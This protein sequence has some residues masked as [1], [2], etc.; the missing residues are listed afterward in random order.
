[1]LAVLAITVLL[2]PASTATARSELVEWD[3][4]GPDRPRIGLLGD[5]TLAGVR[6]AD[7]YGSL[8]RFNYVFDAQSC[9][10]TV[11]RSCWSREQLRPDNAI[12]ALRDHRDRWGQVLVVMMGYNDSASQFDDGVE[13]IVAE[14]RRQ[15]IGQV[16]WLSLRTKGVDY[17]E[18]LHKA[19]GSTYRSANRSLYAA[20]AHEA[21]YLQVADWASA[22]ADRPEWFGPDGVHLSPEGVDALTEFIATQV[23]ALL[24]GRTITPS[25]VPWEVVRSGDQGQIVIDVQT[26]L[27]RAG[28]DE[29]GGAD[30]D[31]GEQTVA[32]VEALQ[33]D[34]DLPITGEVDD[35]TA[36][37]L[38]L[39]TPPAS[40]AG[41][42]DAAPAPP[43]GAT[44]GAAMIGPPLPAQ[45]PGR[46]SGGEG[47]F[48]F[49]AMWTVL[50]VGGLVAATLA[51][52]RF[53]AVRGSQRQRRR[54]RR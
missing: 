6:W 14:A 28:Y 29:V 47:S 16:V 18:P 11:E 39:S 50:V 4:A 8:E 51:P 43:A 35:L 1:M 25:P 19:N 21:G 2:A 46:S 24:A 38:G 3:G 41:Q 23:D 26:A 17:E 54:R 42:V 31:Y 44:A 12:T 49:S 33:R 27:L 32:A 30:G 53:A 9:R 22:S 20:A 36:V 40:A 45:S 52:L 15:G 10:R 13:E 48:A 37:A 7:D 34:R 5:S